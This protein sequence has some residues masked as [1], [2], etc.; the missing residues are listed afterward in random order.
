MLAAM[1]HV[2]GDSADG[3]GAVMLAG[4]M[5]AGVSCRVGGRRRAGSISGNQGD[6]PRTCDEATSY[7]V[8]EGVSALRY[9]RLSPTHETHMKENLQFIHSRFSCRTGR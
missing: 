3:V 4:T 9:R 5:I 2:S 6:Q 8:E 7:S 1:A